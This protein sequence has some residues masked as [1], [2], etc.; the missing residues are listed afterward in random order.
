ML[1]IHIQP[2]G[3]NFI[4]L[5]HTRHIIQFADTICAY[6]GNTAADRQPKNG[7]EAKNNQ[8]FLDGKCYHSA[9][10]KDKVCAVDTTVGGSITLPPSS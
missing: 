1:A 4:T 6:V 5:R 2:R 10:R 9:V 3:H 8:L 7:K